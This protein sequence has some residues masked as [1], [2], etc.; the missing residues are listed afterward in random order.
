M[1]K[2]FLKFVVVGFINTII[3][4]GLLDI[5]M[6]MTKIY[7]GPFY[8]FFKG[9]SFLLANLN[10]YFL[11]KS[12]TFQKGKSFKFSDFSKFFSFSLIGLFLNVLTAYFLVNIQPPF[13]LSP[14]VWANF[15]AFGA[16]IITTFFNFF[17]YR[18]FVFK[19]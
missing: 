9:I 14:L 19:S 7:S 10:S 17:S 2:Q 13:N 1:V 18:Y 12:W 5:L 11:N 4:F 6:F 16:T 3:D 8:A 15:S